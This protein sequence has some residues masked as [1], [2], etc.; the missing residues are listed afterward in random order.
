M[1]RIANKWTLLVCAVALVAV[2][3]VRWDAFLTYYYFLRTGRVLTIR[4]ARVL[5]AMKDAGI[6]VQH[7]TL[8]KEGH[9]C[10]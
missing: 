2:V 3:A 7:L 1:K 6:P 5:L 8:P 9:F 4:E 10:T